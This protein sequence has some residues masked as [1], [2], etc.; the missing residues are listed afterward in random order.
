[1]SGSVRKRGTKWYYSFEA[2]SV[3]GKRK[4]IERVAGRTKKEAEAALRKAEDEYENAGMHFEPSEVSVSDYMDYWLD[5]YVKANCK[6]NTRTGYESIIRNHV[7]PAL[8]MYKLKALTPAVL[9]E[10]I[11]E[12]YLSGYSKNH[13]KGIFNVMSNSMKYAVHPGGFIREN[14]MAYVKMP[15]YEHTKKEINEKVISNDDFNMIIGRFP[16]GST[17]YI[18]LIIGRY[19]GCRIGEV[20]GLTWEDVDFDAGTLSI[21]KIMHKRENGWYFGTTKTASSVRTLKI[22]KTLL[23][24]LRKH[25]KT[26]LENRLLYG[27]HYAQQY[28]IEE[29]VKNEKL[30]RIVEMQLNVKKIKNPVNLICTKE[31]GEMVTP[32]SFKYAARVI[33]YSLGIVFNFHA[34][35]HTH[36]TRLI[37]HGADMKDVQS[38]LGHAKIAT[39]M[40][41]YT[42]ATDKMAEKSVEIFEE[43]AGN[44]PTKK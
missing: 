2:S 3:D 28:E 5:N 24:I 11:Y 8:G 40:D 42:H 15:K 25:K 19:T 14:P 39:T 32:D 21:D 13:L 18:P 36:A 4:R 10:F 34:L 29:I 23:D 41:T 16:E 20:M 12:K 35:R 17:F 26:Q 33:H 44:L 22:G 31:N 43:A 38:R 27:Q 9:Q 7:K 1:M 30:R 37:E 6:Y